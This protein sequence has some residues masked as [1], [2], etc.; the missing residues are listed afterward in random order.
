MQKNATIS[1]IGIIM[2]GNRRW[3]KKNELPLED[4]HE[5][6][7][8][9]IESIVEAAIENGITFLTFYAFSTE[10]WKRNPLEVQKLM[11]VFRKAIHDPQVVRLH[12]MG[13]KVNIIG[14]INAFPK[15][16]QERVSEI[17]DMTQNNN[18]LTA[19]FALN[20]GGRD[21]I[22][23]AV[24]RLIQGNPKKITEQMV[25]DLM[26]TSGQPDPDL[27]IRTGGEQRL[28]NFLTWQAAYSELYFT[29]VLWPDFTPAELGKAILWYQER[30]R[31]FGK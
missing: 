26:D 5:K 7:A 10:N 1:H 8:R 16:I 28:S 19:N 20:Y 24:T 13:V 4:G 14:D 17:H 22:I 6:G 18:R 31:R 29:D 2:D 21:E 23:R 25:S 12:T 27:I 30:E 3:A 9:T 11:M 15:D